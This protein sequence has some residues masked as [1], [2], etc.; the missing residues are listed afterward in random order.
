MND[1]VSSSVDTYHWREEV[2]LNSKSSDARK[3]HMF[4]NLELLYT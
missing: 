1:D 3:M 4:D 2:I